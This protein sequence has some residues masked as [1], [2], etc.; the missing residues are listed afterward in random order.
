MSGLSFIQRHSGELFLCGVLLFV[1]AYSLPTLTTK[2]AYWYDEAINVELARNFADYGKLDLIIAPNTFSGQ[3]ATVGSTGYP[4]TVPLGGFFKLFGFGLAQARVYM[5]LW[6]SACLIALFFVARKL[7]G[8]PAAY[9]S[10]LL[11]ATFAPF[12]GNGRSVMGEIPGFFFFLLSFYFFEERKWWQSGVL[13]GLAVV[14]KPSVFIFLIPAYTLA[15]LASQEKWRRRCITLFKLGGSSLLA[16]FPWLLI[17]ADEIS[18]GGLAAKIL[19]HFKNP[20]SEA[21]VSVAQNIMTNLPT[22][23]TSTTLLYFWMMLLFVGIAFFAERTLFSQHKNL[24]I[25]AAGYLPL[26]LLQYLKSFGY[27]RYLLAAEFIIFILFVISLPAFAR[28]ISKRL[29]IFEKSPLRLP[30]LII[31]GCIVL[32]IV[33]LFL[34]SNIYPSEKTHKTI[35]HLSSTYPEAMIGVFDIPQV[36]SLLPADRKYQYL[37]TYGLWEFGVNPLYLSPEKQPDVLVLDSVDGVLT[38][39]DKA[40]L[41]MFYKE[42][43]DLKDGFLL[44]ERK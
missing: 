42:D 17:Y 35:A 32:Q 26:A 43:V 37:S 41:A 40:V 29:A 10:T 44:Y 1:W 15:V 18:R 3:G 30:G 2:P 6:M 4:V 19:A 24:C 8:S 31:A 16:L 39:D 14:S 21:G 11:V 12:Y 25:L 20:Y 9:A 23:V 33:H 5:L 13:L 22:L 7:L 27:L 36:A 34:F 38:A 28:L